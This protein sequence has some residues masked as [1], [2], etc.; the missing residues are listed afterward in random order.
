[1]ELRVPN[2]FLRRVPTRLKRHSLA[3]AI[4]AMLSLASPLQA[5]TVPAPAPATPGAAHD[6][7]SIVENGVLR[8]GMS[9]FDIP[10]F[11]QRRANGVIEGKEAEFAYQLGHALGVKVV[12]V[13]TAETFD[14]VV[15]LVSD[16]QADIALSAL[17][18]NFAAAKSVRFSAPY[19]T[20]RHALLYDRTAI[21]LEANGGL[22]EDTLRDFRGSLG[23]VAASPFIAFA[24]QNFSMG[25][26]VEYP[27]WKDAIAGLVRHDVDVLYSSEFDVRRTLKEDPVLHIRYGAAVM[28]DRLAFLA[29]AI[30]DSCAKLQE[31]INFY[32][33]QN[34]VSFSMDEMLA[35]R[36][37]N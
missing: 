9:R 32:I 20:L 11:H 37:R 28:K 26:A 36:S 34:N 10:P 2:V 19:M 18:Q 16:G 27:G 15:R 29:V 30:C 17:P 4:A 6:I 8:V 21:A 35:I 24:D 31:F 1:M 12:F 7:K 14:A 3:I 23:I 33:A 5:Q 22:P 25:I 13:D